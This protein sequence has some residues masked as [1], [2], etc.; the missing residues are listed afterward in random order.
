M[1]AVTGDRFLVTYK[2]GHVGQGS[3]QNEEKVQKKGGKDGYD[4]QVIKQ[5]PKDVLYDFL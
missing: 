4:S 1:N 3:V 2:K 5:I